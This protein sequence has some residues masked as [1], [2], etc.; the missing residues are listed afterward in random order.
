MSEATFAEYP[1]VSKLAERVPT[2]LGALVSTLFES[3][4]HIE[5]LLKVFSR[6]CN[7]N[8]DMMQM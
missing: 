6:L 3:R 7:T 2:L 8:S 5:C 4:A 1:S